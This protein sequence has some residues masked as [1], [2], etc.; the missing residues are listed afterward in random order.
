MFVVYVLSKSGSPLMPT[1]RHGWVR[2][3]LKEGRAKV[4]RR[5]PFTIQLT[6][7]SEENVQPLTLGQDIGFKTVGVS[8]TSRTK[9][10]FAAE[11][12]LRTDVSDKVKE[13]AS[14]R[15][16][17]RGK[18][19]RYRQARFDNRRRKS[20]QPSIQQKVQSHEQ[21][22]KDAKKIMPIAVVIIEANN[23]DMAKIN[24]PK[25]N[26]KDYQNGLQKDYY[27]VKQ[28][29]LARDGYQ[30]QA[31]KCGCSEK[32]HV[33]HMTF[34]S[35][36]GSDAPDNL[37]T[38][39]EKHHNELHAGKFSLSVKKHKSL[40]AATMMN[41]V[42]S[43]LLARNPNFEETFGYETKF[44]REKVGLDKTH[45]NDAFIIAEGRG[46]SMANVLYFSQKRRNN[47]SIQ[48]NRKGF[49]P[50]IRRQRYKIQP[51]DIVA[52]EK[53]LYHAGGIQNNGS[54]LMFKDAMGKRIVKPINAFRVIYHQ[55]SFYEE[56]V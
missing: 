52:F 42:R 24:N 48:L 8:V 6:Y 28:Y 12:K 34:R 11:Y 5:L 10:L 13:K 53:K 14:Y 2:R 21:I 25:I 19:T 30:C 1:E 49:K 40:K 22:I 33:H 27:N 56:A 26:G 20:L 3:C 32:L 23:F 50:A 43:Q 39:C 51:K 37:I 7:E 4:V 15:R 45:A 38:I 16:T 31:G 47:R 29:V 35:Q 46:Q 9:E 17:R 44:D 54:Y 55:K 18:K 36:G 41:V